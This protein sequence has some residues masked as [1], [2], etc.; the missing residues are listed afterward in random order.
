MVRIIK[1][2]AIDLNTHYEEAT[3]DANMP[4]IGYKHKK[5][6]KKPNRKLKGMNRRRN[7]KG[8]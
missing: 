3:G 1:L 2:M 4:D 8:V 7:N 5:K 6:R